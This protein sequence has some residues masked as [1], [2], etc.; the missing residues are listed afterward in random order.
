MLFLTITILLLL[1]NNCL[2][3]S[4]VYVWIENKIKLQKLIYS[5]S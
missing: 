4:F 2:Q 5:Y 1:Y 3:Y